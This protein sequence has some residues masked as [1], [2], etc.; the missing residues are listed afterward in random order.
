LGEERL[1]AF[2][3]L[4]IRVD[5]KWNFK[6]FSLDAYIDIQNVLAAVTPSEPSYGLNRNDQG[7]VIDPRSLVIVN[8]NQTGSVLPS[9]GLVVNF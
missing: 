9:L 2:N 5:K 7:N 8:T 4:D 3:Q 6:K 1:D